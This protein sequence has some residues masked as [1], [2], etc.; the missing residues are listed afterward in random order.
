MRESAKLIERLRQAATDFDVDGI[1][2]NMDDF[3]HDLADASALIEALLSQLDAT[4]AERDGRRGIYIA[5]KVAHAQR[6]RDLRAAGVPIISTWIDEAGEGES[7]DLQDLWDRC[8]SE[9]SSAAA[10]I[11]HRELDEVLKGAWVELGAAA[12][13]SVPVFA[14]GIEQFTIARHRRIHHF[15]TFDEALAAALAALKHQGAET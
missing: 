14:V 5:S 10:I 6:W 9:A 11:I 15:A 7:Q 13:H 2:S 8:L 3:P 1:T 4:R 12:S